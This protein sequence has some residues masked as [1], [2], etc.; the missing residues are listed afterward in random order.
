VA[1]KKLGQ[2]IQTKKTKGPPKLLKDLKIHYRKKKG[3]TASGKKRRDSLFTKGK[4]GKS[5]KEE[6]MVSLYKGGKRERRSPSTRNRG[7]NKRGKRKGR[8]SHH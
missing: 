6:K 7:K 2:E 4:R 1:K 8:E 5:E 3:G